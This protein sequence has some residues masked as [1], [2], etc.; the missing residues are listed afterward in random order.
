MA[1]AMPKPKGERPHNA[2]VNT[3]RTETVF[4]NHSGPQLENSARST[5]L[6]HHRRVMAGDQPLLAVPL[7][8]EGVARLDDTA[9]AEGE[10]VETGIDGG[11]AVDLDASPVD[12]TNRLA[13]QKMLEVVLLLRGADPRLVGDRRQQDRL[14]RVVNDDLMCVAGL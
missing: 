10:G 13:L 7:I 1:Q 5:A 6:G 4:R 8:R 14:G 11:V 9:V 3:T 2:L 12:D